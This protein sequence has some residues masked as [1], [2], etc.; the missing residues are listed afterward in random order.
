MEG[1]VVLSG[2][3]IQQF[4][5]RRGERTLMLVLWLEIWSELLGRW[6]FWSVVMGEPCRLVIV[7][8]GSLIVCLVV[9]LVVIDLVVSLILVETGL[10]FVVLVT[11]PVVVGIL[12]FS[13]VVV[14][15]EGR[16]VVALVGGRVHRSVVFYCL[17]LSVT[18]RV[19]Y[20]LLLR[21][22]IRRGLVTLVMGHTVGLAIRLLPPVR[23]LSRS[24]VCP[25]RLGVRLIV[26]STT[27]CP[28]TPPVS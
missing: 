22:A 14:A 17:F 11:N 2:E 8:V 26:A 10:V 20:S 1:S 16:L 5:L 18:R 27:L 15:I 21:N 3:V 19:V 13:P 23:L 9:C 28:I 4:G 24:V 7:A 12:V 6:L 25:I